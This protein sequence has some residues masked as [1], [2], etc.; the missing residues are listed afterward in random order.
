M[1]L[2]AGTFVVTV[3]LLRLF[4][5]VNIQSE[6]LIGG[7]CGCSSLGP[8]TKRVTHEFCGAFKFS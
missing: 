1:G 6:L 7:T 8:I 4:Q 5:Q 3:P 2:S